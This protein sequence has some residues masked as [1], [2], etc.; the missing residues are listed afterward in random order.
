LEKKVLVFVERL[1]AVL[2]M[3][4]NFLDL[5][6]ERIVEA[7]DLTS[8]EKE[9]LLKLNKLQCKCVARKLSETQEILQSVESA[10]GSRTDVFD[11]CEAA[12]K[13]LY[14]VVTDAVLL[15]K[16]CCDEQWLRTAI[17]QHG[18]KSFEDFAEICYEV[19]WCTS[20]LCISLHSAVTRQAAIV[21]LEACDGR[22]G[23]FDRFK[24]ETAVSQDGEDLRSKLELLRQGHVCDVKCVRSQTDP[25]L[26]AQL[27]ARLDNRPTALAAAD[28]PTTTAE[29]LPYLLWKVDY[30]DLPDLKLIGR[31]ASADVLETEWLG[32]K[33]AKKVF[34]GVENKS[35][36][37]E[38]ANLATLFHP[39]V[40]RI[41]CWSEGRRRE[42][43]SL[44]MELMQE[45]LFR[46]L[47]RLADS[48]SDDIDY[49]PLSIF[50]AVDIMLQVA[51]GLKYLHSRR[52]AHR[53]LKSLNVL[54]KPLTGAPELK[55]D[56]GYLNAKLADF[57]LS[58][59]K[60]SSTRFSHQTLNIG[61]RKWMAP[62]VFEVAKNEIDS[63]AVQLPLIAHPFKADVYS[64]ALV[65]YELLTGE[66]PFEG[67]K[68]GEL[69]KRITV[70]RL[71]PELP[72]ECPSRLASLIQRCWEHDPRERPNL[73]EICRELRYVKGLLL[74]G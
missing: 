52:V 49:A 26:A 54:V 65:C 59:T 50:A 46:Y 62:E 40:V 11:R 73:P 64:F 47:N 20:I 18:D 67:E 3:A 4:P 70:D 21:E 23:A 33:Y 29:M 32:E 74:T 24:L 27:L 37:A 63:G 48:G 44:V 43:C 15:I 60:N 45:D 41:V 19:Q 51:R 68:M 12:L 58:K 31:G 1:G 10:A 53:D 72:D 42:N 57:G 34:P 5:A 7:L 66:Q 39:H 22:L 55:Y 13:E 9:Q 14:R 25:C 61:T 56:D 17:R 71:R 69:F 2:I 8:G 28:Q 6:K 30:R 36:E 35:F 16:E 38:S